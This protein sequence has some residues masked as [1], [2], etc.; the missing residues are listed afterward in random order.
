M[1]PVSRRKFLKAMAGAALLLELPSLAACKPSAGTAASSQTPPPPLPTATLLPPVTP[2]PTEQEARLPFFQR[3][4]QRAVNPYLLPE[5]F[6]ANRVQG[7]TRLAITWMNKP[8]FKDAAAGFKGLGANA[9]TRHVKTADEDPW[10]PSAL[11]LDTDGKPLLQKDRQ[12]GGKIDFPAGTNLVKDMVA[13]AHAAGMHMI[14]YYRHIEDKTLAGM[15]GDWVCHNQ[16][17]SIAMDQRGAQLDISGPYRETVL[18]RLLEL[19]EMG[20]DGIYFDESHLPYYG[21]YQ[22]ALAQAFHQATGQDPPTIIKESDPLLIQYLDF[23]ADQM[24]RTFIYWRDTVKQRYPNVVFIIST[25]YLPSL[26]NRRMTTNLAC[27]A[28]SAKNELTLAIDSFINLDVFYGGNKLVQP[29]DDIRIAL[30]WTL[31]RDSAEGRPPHIWAPGFPNEAHKLAFTGA[32]VTYGG[33]A[34][35][36]VTEAYLLHADD[37]EGQTER[38]GAQQAFALGSQVSPYLASMQPLRWA[39]IHYSE[40]ARN[41]RGSNPLLEWREVLWPVTGAFREFVRAGLPVGIVNDR[42]LDRG[43]LDGYRLLFLPNPNELLPTQKEIIAKFKASGGKVIENQADWQWSLPASA[44]KAVSSFQTALQKFV[45]DSPLQVTGAEGKR[46]AVAYRNPTNN[47]LVVALTQDFS[48]LQ[49]KIKNQDLKEPLR[50]PPPALQGVAINVSA[51]ILP[52]K[53][54]EIISGQ[55][56]VI[57][58]TS[59]GYKVAVPPFA[60]MALVV[61]E[62]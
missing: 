21:C 58:N 32:V 55:D 13:N 53:V 14:A 34:N 15:H 26:T 12:I 59:S 30:G 28:D 11:P 35:I 62:P 61:I 20:V 4:W 18:Q 41:K 51:K 37:A 60:P 46:H 56:L 17:S 2:I 48:W 43:L 7:H 23:Q 44:E 39:A 22:T 5:W 10:W 45:A 29:P 54:T 33:V 27:I 52:K 40:L 8:E 31:L 57:E 19:A 6:L 9:F 47:Q 16:N 24:E 3:N 1:K 38:A 25:T 50:Q 42:Q 36:D 49:V